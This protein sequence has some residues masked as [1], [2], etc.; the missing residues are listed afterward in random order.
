MPPTCPH[1]LGEADLKRKRPCDDIRNNAGHSAIADIAP[2][3]GDRCLRTSRALSS[4]RTAG[5]RRGQ[6]LTSLFWTIDHSMP[7]NITQA[8][9]PE[10]L[11]AT[12]VSLRDVAG[13]TDFDAGHHGVRNNGL[14]G[15]SV[16]ATIRYHPTFWCLQ[17]LAVRSRWHDFLANRLAS[18]ALAVFRLTISAVAAFAPSSTRG[19]LTASAG[20]TADAAA[21]TPAGAAA[22]DVQPA[23]LG[24]QEMVTALRA[25]GLPVSAIADVVDVER[26]TVYA[27]EEGGVKRCRTPRTPNA[28]HGFMQRLQEGRNFQDRCARC[29]GSGSVD[30]RTA[31]AF[32]PSFWIPNIDVARIR[33]AVNVLRPVGRTSSG[34]ATASWCYLGDASFADTPHLEA[35]ALQ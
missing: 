14:G 27:W 34:N 3:P 28:F 11:K 2:T 18:A 20:V 8:L 7:L 6:R 33:S 22:A 35:I 21:A 16:N 10:A 30:Y 23:V 13:H 15:K 19:L 17:R 26:K 1:E 32:A 5:C 25:E 12:F 9:N 4:S 29:I 24:A 31:S